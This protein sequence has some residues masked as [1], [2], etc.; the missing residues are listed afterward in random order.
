MLYKNASQDALV[1]SNHL[2]DGVISSK[3]GTLEN[4]SQGKKE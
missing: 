2:Q 3:N 1:D 4:R